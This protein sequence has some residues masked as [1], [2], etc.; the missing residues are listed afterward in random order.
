MTDLPVA[1]REELEDVLGWV[2]PSVAAQVNAADGTH[3]LVLEYSDRRQVECVVLPY[4]RR[5]ALCVSTQVG[6]NAGCLFCATGQMGFIRNLSAAEI[7]AQ[8]LTAQRVTGADV[9]HVVFM[10]MGEPLWNTDAVL[11]AIQVLNRE[12][13]ISQR[14]ITVSTIGVI[15]E[16]RRLIQLRPA[17]TL[18]LSLHATDD[19]LRHHLMPATRHWS[20]SDTLQCLSDYT[21]ATGRKCTIEYVLIRQ[22]NDSMDQ[23]RQLADLVRPLTA[24]VNLIPVNPA[25]GSP[26]ASPPPEVINRFAHTL[27][28]AGIP[29]VVRKSRGT[30]IHAACGQLQRSLSTHAEPK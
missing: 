23:A 19:T 13:G 27:V 15:P 29:A 7:V 25:P 6:C 24:N 17:F 10:G 28:D 11:Q 12:V 20:L 26:Y 5:T 9:T 22:I 1:L 3:R 8:L 4:T 16:M 14:R 18:A 30:D 2:L 21:L